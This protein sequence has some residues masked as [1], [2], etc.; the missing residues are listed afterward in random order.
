MGQVFLLL[1]SDGVIVVSAHYHDGGDVPEG[2]VISPEP[3]D[4]ILWWH[5]CT[6]IA[7]FGILFPTG[8]VLG[9]VRSR[10][11]VPLQVFYI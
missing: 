11:H 4:S 10:W 2:F 3:L 8:M 1:L 5:I 6:M 9:I 7:A